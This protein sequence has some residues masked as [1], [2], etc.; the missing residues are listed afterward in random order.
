MVLKEGQFCPRRVKFDDV[1][2]YWGW[3]Q[4]RKGLLLSS[5]EQNAVKHC[6][7]QPSS[8]EGKDYLAP[9]AGSSETEKP[10]LSAYHSLCLVCSCPSSPLSWVSLIHRRPSWGVIS[11]RKLF[12]IPPR[13]PGCPTSVLPHTAYH[14]II[15]VSALSRS[16]IRGSHSAGNH[17]LS[18]FISLVTSAKPSQVA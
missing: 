7:M 10:C 18:T 5:K 11:S 6:V 15:S 16:W 4:L 13:W 14:S 9:H 3:P 12:L 17:I 8:P 1:Q 2:R